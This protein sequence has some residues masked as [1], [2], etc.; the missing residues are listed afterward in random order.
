MLQYWCKNKE[1]VMKYAQHLKPC[2]KVKEEAE[3]YIELR[4]QIDCFYKHMDESATSKSLK[5]KLTVIHKHAG[6]F[7][8]KDI[9]A[10]AMALLNE[11]L[12]NVREKSTKV[13][14]LQSDERSHEVWSAFSR[15]F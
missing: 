14:K 11:D 2:A 10:S 5:N 15:L 8:R 6:A 3:R 9:F 1:E 7:V 13:A 12:K 4:C